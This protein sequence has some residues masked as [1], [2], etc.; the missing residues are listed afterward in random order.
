MAGDTVEAQL[1]W[2][3]A[4]ADTECEFRDGCP[5]HNDG[6]PRPFGSPAAWPVEHWGE[7]LG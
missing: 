4:R 2:V 1:I 3:R 5:K 6:P 7:R